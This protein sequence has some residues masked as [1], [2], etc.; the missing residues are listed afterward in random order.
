[1]DYLGGHKSHT[2]LKGEEGR[3]VREM[4]EKAGEMRQEGMTERS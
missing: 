1:M 4:R 2:P 3:K